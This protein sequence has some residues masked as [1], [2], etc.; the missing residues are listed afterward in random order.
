MH[1]SWCTLPACYQPVLLLPLP[2]P[3]RSPIDPLPLLGQN[4]VLSTRWGGTQESVGWWHQGTALSVTDTQSPAHTLDPSSHC[5]RFVLHSSLLGCCR[6]HTV[7]CR[8]KGKNRCP[9]KFLSK[10]NYLGIRKPHGGG[11]RKEQ[12]YYFQICNHYSA[13]V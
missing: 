2:T 3:H 12:M 6:S 13:E 10:R 4:P 7:T 5:A 11:E 9:N 1:E 8:S